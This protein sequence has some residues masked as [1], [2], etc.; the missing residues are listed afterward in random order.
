MTDSDRLIK[1][2]Y[3]DEASAL[4]YLDIKND[5]RYIFNEEEIKNKE[6]N[7]KN[8]NEAKLGIGGKA[9]ELLK[10]IGVEAKASTEVSGGFSKS[11]HKLFNSSIS[12]TILTDFLKNVD[13][14]GKEVVTFVDYDFRVIDNSF[15][16]I[17]TIAPI[18]KL[19]KDGYIDRTDEFKDINIK[20]IESVLENSKGYFEFLAVKEEKEVILRLN[21]NE[22]RNNYR[23][24]DLQDMNLVFYGIKV[25]KLKKKDLKIE[26]YFERLDSKKDSNTKDIKDKQNIQEESELLQDFEGF[27][28]GKEP[29]D[30]S[31]INPI[32]DKDSLDLYDIVLAGI[33]HEKD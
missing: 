19:L 10:Y 21:T 6:T 3:F 27:S 17:K 13:E 31:N 16:Y 22:L 23:F 20:E 1:V 8:N 30:K 15:A 33:G 11:N 2:V 5:G 29:I 28:E 4:E 25:G 14:S 9:F 26:N 12:N 24:G 7:V 32:V 18:L